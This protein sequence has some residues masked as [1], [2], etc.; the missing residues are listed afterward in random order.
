[1]KET[2]ILLAVSSLPG[3]HGAGDLGPA[4]Y[5]WIDLLRENGVGV[6]QLLPLNPTGYGNSPYQPYSSR[7]GDELYISLEGLAGEGL[8]PACPP[9]LPA[10]A[11]ID[12]GALRAWRE[13]WLRQAFAAFRPDE[14]Y[15][16][17]AARDWVRDYAAFRAFKQANGLRAWL[18]WPADQRDWPL[19]RDPAVLAGLEEEAAYHTFLQYEFLRQWNGVHEHAR[20]AGV[21]ILGD[22][23][24][25]VG[26]DSVDVWAGRE[27]FLLD[28]DGRPTFIAGVPPDYFSA[29]GQRWGNPIYDWDRLKETGYQ[30]WVD[31]IGYDQTL[32]DILRVDHFRAFDTFWKIPASCPTAMEGAWIEAP[33][34][35]VLDRLREA[36]PGLELVAEDLG[37]LRPQVLALRDEYELPGMKV[38]EF[39]LSTKGKYAV[40]KGE[41]AERQIL[42]TGTHDNATLREW[43]ESLTPAARRK[44]RRF[45][46]RRGLPGG[47]LEGLRLYALRSP[48]RLV[49]LPAQDLL[50]LGASARL[51][52]PGTLGS[53]NWE[54][55]L[56]G[57]EG[58][59]RALAALR[60]EIA[61]RSGKK[62]ARSHA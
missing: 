1:M 4:A 29:T 26:I 43:Y 34:R 5:E 24:F 58:L 23:P 61:A 51:N 36:V 54:W 9:P 7:A 55:K 2:G 13:P 59:R 11:R 56:T 45:L 28:G 41:A 52:L 30:F 22:V 49:V 62:E 42:Y 33:G 6:W 16:E 17:F 12:Y 32:Y 31:R 47:P 8:L 19:R 14:A 10:A 25:Y 18:E 27:N 38:L 21:K 60:P 48:A 40:D 57:W 53:P 46:R 3:P 15:R 44:V 35:A 37:D 20:A 39:A 50:E